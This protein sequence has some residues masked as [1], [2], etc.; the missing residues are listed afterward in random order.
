MYRHV[1]GNAPGYHSYYVRYLLLLPVIFLHEHPSSSG[2][3]CKKV[4]RLISQLT[5]SE[6][7]AIH[8]GHRTDF[9]NVALGCSNYFKVVMVLILVFNAIF[10]LM[11]HWCMG[12][13]REGWNTC[14][15]IGKIWFETFLLVMHEVALR[16]FSYLATQ[17]FDT[18]KMCRHFNQNIWLEVILGWL[19]FIPL[20]VRTLSKTRWSLS[21]QIVARFEYSLFRLDLLVR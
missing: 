10:V 12:A 5:C 7:K 8:F 16:K 17:R 9:S 11:F 2:F 13:K 14:K 15:A 19:I 4:I 21:E 1:I 20:V 6:R 18:W 3:D